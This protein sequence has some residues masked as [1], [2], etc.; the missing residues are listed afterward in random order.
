MISD[1]DLRDHFERQYAQGGPTADIARAV[2]ELIDRADSFDEELEVLGDYTPAEAAKELE[3]YDSL[4]VWAEQ[5]ITFKEFGDLD[6]E[7]LER[8][9][10]AYDRYEQRSDDVST[11][12]I[13]AGLLPLRDYETDPL[14]LIRMFLPVD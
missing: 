5:D 6:E 3:K 9:A 10:R 1:E 4:V 2:L 11:L 14:P 12:A 13:E 8:F 7:S